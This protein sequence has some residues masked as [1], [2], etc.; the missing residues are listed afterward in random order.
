MVLKS[1][2]FSV[3]VEDDES[4]EVKPFPSDKMESDVKFE[5]VEG[6]ANDGLEKMR[7]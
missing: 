4:N 2:S 7:C 3:V 6:A 1:K 5:D